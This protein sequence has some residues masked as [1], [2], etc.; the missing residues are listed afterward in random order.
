MKKKLTTKEVQTL[1][2]AL[3]ALNMAYSCLDEIQLYLDDDSPVKKALRTAMYSINRAHVVT[4]YQA[5][6]A[7]T[8]LTDD[9]HNFFQ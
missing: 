4:R 8:C 6:S 2:S 3:V 7:D 5:I 1:E 9:L